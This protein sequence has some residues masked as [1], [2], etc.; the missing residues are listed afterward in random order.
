MSSKV[1]HR[2]HIVM[3]ISIRD[4]KVILRV[5]IHETV[6]LLEDNLLTLQK[7]LISSGYFY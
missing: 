3:K 5:K 1:T 4:K 6:I 7:D 2:V